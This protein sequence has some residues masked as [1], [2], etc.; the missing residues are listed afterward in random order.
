MSHRIA[1][2]PSVVIAGSVTV[3][4]CSSSA[5]PS[6]D[7]G[8]EAGAIDAPAADGPIPIVTTAISL[9]PLMGSEFTGD[10]GPEA[11]A[12]VIAYTGQVRLGGTQSFSLL[13]DTG[14][15]PVVVAS[16]SC[17]DCPG[18]TP[19]YSPGAAATELHQTGTINYGA[20]GAQGE[21]YTDTAQL[22]SLQA[23]PV[24]VLA[25]TTV[26]G[27]LGWG[28]SYQGVLGLNPTPNTLVQ[29]ERDYF[30]QLVA[31]QG[32]ADVFAVALC[33]EGGSLWLGGYDPSAVTAPPAFV[34]ILPHYGR[35][36]VNLTGMEVAGQSL[37]VPTSAY[38]PAVPDT[39]SAVI[40]VGQTIFDSAIAAI[41]RNADFQALFGGSDWFEGPVACTT[42]SKTAAELNA[43]LPTLTLKFGSTSIEATATTSYLLQLQSKSG[44][45]WCPGLVSLGAH[46]CLG[47][48]SVGDSGPEAGCPPD[49]GLTILGDTFLRS[50][51]VIFDQRNQRIG[52]APHA[53]P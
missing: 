36:L 7:A 19:L 52:F 20:G 3:L 39:G 44:T 46:N 35:F 27:T 41:A 16:A 2:L 48:A 31:K 26:M 5:S 18:V 4:G 9:T 6:S 42:V 34:P 40:A 21:L 22:G 12:T 50:Q 51:V 53:C 49:T 15:A 37:A 8:M 17:G 10:A 30:P 38:G 33:P 29:G 32:F 28:P 45:R 43:L 25:I 11:G 23:V 13:V 24:T 47:S 1:L 14:S